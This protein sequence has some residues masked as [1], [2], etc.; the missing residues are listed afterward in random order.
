MRS[1]KNSL[2]V[3]AAVCVA[4]FAEA[5]TLRDSFRTMNFHA[6]TRDG[7]AAVLAEPQST[8]LRAWYIANLSR[9]DAEAAMTAARL[10]RYAHPDDAWSWFAM[11]AAQLQ[12]DTEHEHAVDSAEK[13][14]ALYKGDDVEVP[15]MYATALRE[16]ARY[17]EVE[18]FLRRKTAPWALAEAALALD[19]RAWRDSK[20]VDA[21]YAAYRDAETADPQDV[22]LVYAHAQSLS[23]RRRAAEA[24]PLWKRALEL[25]PDSVAI[26]SA[27][28]RSLGK[29]EKAAVTED[30]AAFLARD[31]DDPAALSAAERAY[32]AIGDTVNQEAMRN[33]LTSE[34]PATN[35]AQAAMYSYA[36]DYFIANMQQVKDPAV[37]AEMI[38]RMRQF[39]D[40]PY[41]P[42]RMWV[43]GAYDI[44]FRLTKDDAPIA[45]FLQAVD[46]VL[47]YGD[48]AQR[49]FNVAEA[50]A[51]RGVRLEQAEALAREGLRDARVPLE[52][53]R[54]SYTTEEFAR[55][56]KFRTSS[57]QS[58]LGWVLLQRKKLAEA[59]THLR[60]AVRLFPDNAAAH[61]HLGKWYEALGR[62]AKAEEQYATGLAK[63][64]AP[65]TDNFDAL[66]ALYQR[67]HHDS[68]EGWDAYIAAMR[69]GSASQ[70]KLEVLAS[71]IAPARRVSPFS[72][73]DLGGQTVSLASLKGKVVVVKF[74]GTWCAPCVGEMPEFQK[75]VDRYASDP[76]VAIV[77]I[78]SDRDA[79]LPREFMKKNNYR[80]PVLLDDGWITRATNVHAYPTTWF[81]T[82]DGRV[83]FEKSGL[84]A[85][86]ADEFSWRIEA[87]RPKR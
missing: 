37:R 51:T 60:E 20:L 41:Q 9:V 64:R 76:S 22:R 29:S 85:H 80:F 73:K 84:S 35:E 78:D 52:Q 82:A 10:L 33:R 49:A 69:E 61:H 19:A 23:A 53:D 31:H 55:A 12:S 74:W 6:G 30:I 25:S 3:L 72:L 83:A 4:A 36:V 38:R 66:R 34:F 21:A 65:N 59:G 1:G 27:Y 81:L 18:A 16:L 47:A 63:E 42:D 28:W 48:R 11:T 14:I 71:R 8:E 26:R 40:Y 86:M 43:A 54:S 24:A 13:M 15:R 77:T 17:D 68:M 75:I 56:V 79:A 32:H 45:D 39:L 87:L 50:L 7:A 57:A 46:G 58:A 70:E 44:L 5:A 62:N 2:Y 67:R